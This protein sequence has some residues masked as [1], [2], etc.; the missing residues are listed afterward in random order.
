MQMEGKA[1]LINAAGSSSSLTVGKVLGSGDT[2]STPPGSTVDLWLGLN[3]DW[4]RV[5]PETTLK[6]EVLDIPNISERRVTTSLRLIKGSVTG[7]VKTKL[8]AD[9]KYEVKTPGGVAD[10]RGTVY[11]FLSNG[12]LIVTKGVVNFTYVL[13]GV[14]K[15]VRVEPGYQFKPGDEKPTPAPQN[16]LDKVA[17][18]AIQVADDIGTVRDGNLTVTVRPASP[19][20][21]EVS[22]SGK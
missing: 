13:K 9:S 7:N 6:F 4:L 10:I 8:T 17:Q 15:T 16:L 3:G 2:V 20:P 21:L 18:V 22:T 5:D 14:S 11:A 1:T 19:N 12:T